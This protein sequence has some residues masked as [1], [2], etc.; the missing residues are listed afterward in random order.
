MVS[1]LCNQNSKYASQLPTCGGG[2]RGRG[3]VKQL[4]KVERVNNNEGK[5]FERMML[6]YVF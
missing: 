6:G 2:W 5:H 3:D 1:F 4:N